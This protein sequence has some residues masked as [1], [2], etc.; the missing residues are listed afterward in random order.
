MNMAFLVVRRKA[1]FL[2]V[3]T[4]C[5]TFVAMTAV[6]GFAAQDAKPAVAAQAAGEDKPAATPTEGKK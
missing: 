1:W 2:L 6:G 3:F 5:T 4:L